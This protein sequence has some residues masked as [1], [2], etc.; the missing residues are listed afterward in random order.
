MSE[1]QTIFFNHHV[2]DGLHYVTDNFH[3]FPD[4]S[5]QLGDTSENCILYS[6]H[7][8]CFRNGLP[9]LVDLWNQVYRS[10]FMAHEDLGHIIYTAMQV[11]EKFDPTAP[12]N[13]TA[14]LDDVRAMGCPE[15]ADLVTRL[16]KEKGINL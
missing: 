6:L 15:L 11:C 13:I 4:G 10:D 3:T 5:F 14:I 12:D 9:R 16:L 1:V 7:V 2:G 8:M